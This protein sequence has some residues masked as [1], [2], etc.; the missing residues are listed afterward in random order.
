VLKTIDMRNLMIIPV[1]LL[2]VWISFFPQP[3]QGQYQS[4]TKIFL[5]MVFV[6]LLI[7]KRGR[8]FRSSDWPL[9]FFI[10]ALSINVFFAQEQNIAL[11]TYL[12]LALP[13][14]FIY[15]IVA[16]T[17]SSDE[18]L[19]LFS[20]TICISSMVVAMVGILESIF[21][22]NPLYEY[23]IENPF[24]KQYTLISAQ[25][26][27]TQ[28][29]HPILGTY[30]IACLPF[31]YL[32]F[33]QNKSLWRILGAAGIILNSTVAILTFSRGV[34][35]VLIAMLVFYLLYGKKYRQLLV[36]V[37]ILLIF[38]IACS[39]SPYPVRKY[40]IDSMTFGHS[41]IVSS[42]RMERVAMT[43]R[44]IREHPLKG[45]GFQHI[46]IHFNDY[47]RGVFKVAYN[48]KIADNMYLTILGEAGLIGFLGFLIFISSVLGKARRSLRVLYQEPDRREQQRLILTGLV[49]LLVNMGCYELFYWISPYVFFCIFIALVEAG[50]R[51][52][53]NDRTPWEGYTGLESS[54]FAPENQI[55]R[56]P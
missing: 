42:Y 45:I 14:F 15:Y 47:Y 28:F 11:Q 12:N 55:A 9:W 7:V 1:I 25:P 43:G 31:S 22:F 53:L 56:T 10:A 39:L 54:I 48:F 18:K 23:F 8:I 6:C 52:T 41:G 24:Y 35:L 34:F 51:R 21:R 29:H 36:L 17:I 26:V 44:I 49:A 30:L 50:Y 5:W 38:T 16:E 40:G 3:I 32:L 27:S 46:R 33:K 13:L 19:Q 2:F 4:V 37:L 20:K